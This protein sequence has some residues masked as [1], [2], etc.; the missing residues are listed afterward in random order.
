MTSIKGRNSVTNEQKL[1]GNNPIL[2]R[3]NINAYTLRKNS[4]WSPYIF[5]LVLKLRF[6][7]TKCMLI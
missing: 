2:D 5:M 1:S 7:Y 6:G 3:A 4:S